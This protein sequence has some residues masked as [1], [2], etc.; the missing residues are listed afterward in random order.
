MH[1]THL[2]VVLVAP[3][4]LCGAAQALEGHT[5]ETLCRDEPERVARLFAALDLD[6]P[7]LEAARDAVAQQAWPEACRAL[8]DYYLKRFPYTPPQRPDEVDA[9]KCP[10]ADAILEDRFTYYGLTD[11][12]ARTSSGGLE[13]THQGPNADREWAW[14]LNRHP[15]LGV[16]LDAFQRTGKNV[17]AEALDAHLQDWVLSSPY[18]GTRSSTA[19]WRGLEAA[20]RMGPWTTVFRAIQGAS[21]FRPATRLLMLSSLPNHAHYLRHFHADTGNWVTMEMYG[22]ATIALTWPEFQDAP[23]WLDYAITT[24]IPEITRQV[25]PDGVQMELTSH[26]HH[27]AARNLQDF[28]G[29]VESSGHP[30]PEDF[31]AGLERMWN[32]LA[33]SMRPNGY[34]VLNNDSDYDYTRVVMLSRA[35]QYQRADWRYIA[36]NGK[37]G[38]PPKGLPSVFFPWAGQLVMRSGWDADAHWAFFD[39]GPL[40]TGHIHFDKLHLSIALHGRDVLVDA[41]RYTYVGGPWRSYFVGSSSHNV[42]LVDGREQRPYERTTHEPLLEQCAIT[43]DYDYARGTFNGGYRDVEG[44]TQHTR[45]VVYMKDRYWLVLDRVVTSRPRALT[46]LWHFH[47]QC[48][49]AEENGTIVTTDAGE[50]NLRVVPAS[51]NP[52]A[53]RLVKGQTEPALQGWYSPHYNQKESAA[54]A[55]CECQVDESTTFA[56]LMLPARGAVPEAHLKLDMITAD[57]AQV[58]VAIAG[59]EVERLRIPF[60]GPPQVSRVAT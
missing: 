23:A 32:Y 1:P 16:L 8:L 21:P 41:G 33:Y 38:E 7:G 46:A 14:G 52:W 60:A 15:H 2:A 50:G 42:I 51:R 56:W 27:V 55:V 29:R 13:W 36:T 40:G 39:I 44:D 53:I 20:L 47:P 48:T 11:T 12:I 6:H 10:E 57:E 43:E 22:L 25:Y 54:V 9:P 17:Y 26:Y 18:P 58:A 4:M 3:M 37:E 30:L 31:S 35:E 59:E 49:V 28:A 45:V 19:Q 34:G 5:L 24:I